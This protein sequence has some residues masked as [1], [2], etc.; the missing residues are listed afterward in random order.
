MLYNYALSQMSYKD[1]RGKIHK[2]NFEFWRPN[3][4]FCDPIGYVS[5]TKVRHTFM[6]AGLLSPADDSDDAMAF[7]I[8]N[9]IHLLN[10]YLE[11]V[12]PGAFR[13]RDPALG[14]KTQLKKSK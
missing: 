2:L 6:M 5:P 3:G 4:R 12:S 11:H 7:A 8:E 9:N 10:S 13:R 14:N 1:Q